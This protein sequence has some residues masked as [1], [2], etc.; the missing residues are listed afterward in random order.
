MS[1]KEYPALVMPESVERH[2]VKLWA[3]GT[4]LDADIYRPRH[5]ATA[6]P[7]VALSHGW[8]GSK[9]TCERYAAKFAEAGMVALT[10]TQAC[11]FGSGSRYHAK[12]VPASAAGGDVVH[13][14]VQVIR[15]YIDPL[16]W[17]QSFQA[18]IDY[19][20]G[21]PG[22]DPGRLGA[23]GTSLGGG[24]ALHVAAN[25]A[26][27]KALAVQVAIVGALPGKGGALAKK[28]A[29]DLARGTVDSTGPRLDR[30]PGLSGATNLAKWAHFE[31][32]SQVEKLRIPT[33][34]MDAGN[35]EMMKTE[36]NCGLI[37]RILSQRPGQIEKYMVIPDIDHY[38]IYFGGYET[39]SRE[40]VAWFKMHL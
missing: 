21:E 20:E 13:A 29:I 14:D 37:H 18:A 11:W 35:E 27:V 25:D 39:G 3:N 4:A 10:F 8:G 12:G 26:R 40:A 30:I 9:A 7:A 1:Q 22:V 31:P 19:L 38:G 16:D 36:E 5:A 15:D 33:L 32:I 23:W 17:L 24:V 6:L 28:R 34:M 2:T